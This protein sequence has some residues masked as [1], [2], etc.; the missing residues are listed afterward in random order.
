MFYLI[1]HRAAT[2]RFHFKEV[3]SQQLSALQGRP[4]MQRAALPTFTPFTEQ[5]APGDSAKWGYK[6]RPSPITPMRDMSQ[7]INAHSRS[8]P[9]VSWG[10]VRLALHL[11]FFPRPTLFP[12]P[13]FHMCWSLRKS[14]TPDSQTPFRH[15]IPENLKYLQWTNW[16]ITPWITET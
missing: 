14:Y 11:H 7:A 1:R 9:L 8:S 2:F 12:S 4:Q 5:P 3:D 15:L 13:S 16:I 10:F 6:E